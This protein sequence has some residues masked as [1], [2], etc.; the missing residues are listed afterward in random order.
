MP[1]VKLHKLDGTDAF[2]V[3]DLEDAANS[4]GITRLAPKIL[5]DGATMLARTNT[6]LFASFEQQA[7]GASAGINAKPEDR[8]AAIAAFVA[9]V[10]PLVADGTFLTEP[11]KGLSAADFAPLLAVDPRPD[12][13]PAEGVSLLGATAAAAAERALGSSGALA[14]AT[15]AIEGL[16]VATASVVTSVV[17]RGGRVTALATTKG[18]ITNEAGFDAAAVVAALASKGADALDELGGEVKPAW[19]VFGAPVDVLFTGS[20]TGAVSDAGA[21]SITA[22]VVVPIAPLAVTAKALAMLRRSGSVVIPDFLSVSG[23]MFA[24]FRE[25]GATLDDVRQVAEEQVVAVL[26]EVLDHADGPLLGA[27]YRAEAFL[28]TWRDTLP[29]GRPLA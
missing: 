20:K 3:F 6:Y 22:K 9:E 27:C 7:G 15:V 2:I 11:G 12:F 19:S 25:D 23:P 1:A 10:E 28:R 29:F 16:D 13:D 21:G 26:D 18:A 24:S 14:G 8:E 5:V 4:I 17:E